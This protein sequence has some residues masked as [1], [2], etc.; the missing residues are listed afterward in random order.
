MD[1]PALK[2]GGAKCVCGLWYRDVLVRGRAGWRIRDR[3]EERS[4]IYNMPPDLRGGTT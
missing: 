2:R 4:Y 3:Y 1:V